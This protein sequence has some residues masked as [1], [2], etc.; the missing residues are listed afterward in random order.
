MDA[1][2]LAQKLGITAKTVSKRARILGIGTQ[3]KIPGKEGRPAT[4]YNPEECDRIASY[5][6]P[7]N[8]THESDSD[9]EGASSLLYGEIFVLCQ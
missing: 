3:A 4:V 5:G 7:S 6:K 9:D 2:S 1:K 8:P